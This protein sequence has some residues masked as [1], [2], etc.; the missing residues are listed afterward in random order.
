MVCRF[1]SNV[2]GRGNSRSREQLSVSQNNCGATAPISGRTTSQGCLSAGVVTDKGVVTPQTV[3]ATRGIQNVL[4]K[5]NQISFRCRRSY[6]N[7]P[8][9]LYNWAICNA[10]SVGCHSLGHVAFAETIAD[11]YQ[12]R[13]YCNYPIDVCVCQVTALPLIKLITWCPCR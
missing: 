3:K 12:V 8:V 2:I 6:C 7:H 9:D 4:Y 10:F 11:W 13:K 1:L 5:E